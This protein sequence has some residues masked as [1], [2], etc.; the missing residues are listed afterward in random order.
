MKILLINLWPVID[1]KGGTEKVFFNMANALSEKG[2]EVVALACE[3][4]IGK[5]FFDVSDKVLFINV[6]LGYEPKFTVYQ[7]I[8]GKICGNRNTRHSYRENIVDKQKAA[9][10]APVVDREKPDVI[11]SY[12]V[13]A[14]RLLKRHL[15][16]SCPIVTMFHFNPEH[17]LEGCTE[18]TKK[19]LEESDC[20]QVLLPSFIEKTKEYIHNTDVVYI[21]N[22]V[23]Q[24]ED[25]CGY[26][27]DN[28]IINV[29]RVDSLQ[30][31][32][33]LLIK[34]FCKIAKKYSSWKVEF[35]GD[36]ELGDEKYYSYCNKL[37]F[38]NNLQDRIKFCGTSDDIKGKLLRAKIFA[39]PSSFE[40]FSLALTEAMS[41]G[42]PSVGY[43]NAISVNELI[44]DGK[45]GIL[46]DYGVDS[47][48]SA[49]SILIENDDKRIEM[50]K[51]AKK[52]MKQ[53]APENIWNEWEKLI[54]KVV[55]DN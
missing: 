40:G 51:A 3:N 54:F 55:N 6:G 29:S 13:G 30:K 21:P 10:I 39:F 11:I 50:G 25:D 46:C 19:A 1:S 2:N 41:A 9:L 7:N 31:R 43:K 8:W 26:D 5:P 36:V 38:E 45:T 34:A 27:R 42:L 17:I 16:I 24:Y 44:E 23:P 20:I 47:L 35:W 37:I 22:C 18:D 53:Y 12:N 33:D 49:L 32:Q 28:I 4:K 15:K 48:A 14:T 52:S